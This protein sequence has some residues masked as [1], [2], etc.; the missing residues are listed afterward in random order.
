MFRS[1][2]LFDCLAKFLPFGHIGIIADERFELVSGAFHPFIMALDFDLF[3]SGRPWRGLLRAGFM[4]DFLDFGT[5]H[6]LSRLGPLDHSFGSG[7][8]RVWRGEKVHGADG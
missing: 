2:L 3:C 8:R 7:F 5:S 6:F 1:K 4:D